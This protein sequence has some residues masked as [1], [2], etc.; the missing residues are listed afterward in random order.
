MS[1]IKLHSLTLGPLATNCYLVWQDGA[2]QSL[3]VDAAG[4]PRD[5][6]QAAAQRHLDIN[7]L[8]NTHG[9]SDHAEAVAALRQLAG[10]A[11]AIHELDAP[12][13][14]D[15]LLSGAAM[16]GFPHQKASPDRLL[17][18]GDRIELPASDLHLSVLHTPGHTPG[19]ICLLGDGVF[20]SGDCLF[21]G[22]I[23]RTDLPGGD[24]RAM[25][26][27][28]RRLATLDPHLIVYPGHGPPTTI[29]DELQG[30]PWLSE[31]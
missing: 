1:G 29:A 14:S 11:L 31:L 7:L 8:V 2:S 9:H 25:L 20:F 22:G 5:F 24:D 26:A 23:G 12:M 16:W 30:H 19:S 4:D 18:E 13:L 10:A 17:K 6:L 27:S 28:L 15:P 3:L 21:A